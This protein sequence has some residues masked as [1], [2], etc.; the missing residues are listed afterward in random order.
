MTT[1]N[2]INLP[3]GAVLQQVGLQK[4]GKWEVLNRR[5]FIVRANC[6]PRQLGTFTHRNRDDVL[7]DYPVVI[8]PGFGRADAKFIPLDGG[9]PRLSLT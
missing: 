1:D 2:R 6:T 5:T 3:A 4:D 9:I 8:V 7:V